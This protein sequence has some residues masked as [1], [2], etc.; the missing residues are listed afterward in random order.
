MK[1]VENQQLYQVFKARMAESA[2]LIQVILG[3]RQVGKTSFIQHFTKKNSAKFHFVD[4][5]TISESAWISAQWQIAH[6]NSQCLI[7][8]EIQKIP[9]WSE[10]IKKLW[11]ETKRHKKK[12]KC[13]LLGSSSLSLNTGLSESLTGRFELVR[14]FHW[15][16]H[17]SNQLKKMNLEDYIHFGGYPG[18]YQHLSDPRRWHD[19]LRSSIIE[20]VISKD[21][22]LQARIKSPA[23]FRQSFYI[24][25]NLPAQVMSYNKI[26]GQLQDQGN[27]DLVKYYIELFEAAFL[28]RTVTKYSKNEI[29]KK[30]S[31]PKII[32]MAP[33]LSTFHRL[34]NLPPEYLGRVFEAMVGAQF[35]RHSDNLYYWADGDYEVDYVTELK[36]QTIAIEVKS[37]RN[38]KSKSLEKFRTKYPKSKV[39]FIT[40]DNY[41]K[42]ESNPLEFIATYAT[43]A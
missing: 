6:Q 33:S 41:E 13:I 35:L 31:S 27:I 5:D 9:S 43:S 29:R 3:P 18:S 28:I 8:D 11:D 23:L 16:F 38:K 25:S 2:P 39:I 40:K 21:I 15:N 22:L 1:I 30:Q 24:L 10:M 7:I 34:D 36:G 20:T 42:Y 12:Q 4:G 26:L 37:G 17:E 19:Y 32:P 14:A